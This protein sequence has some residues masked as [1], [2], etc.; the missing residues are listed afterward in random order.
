MKTI[1]VYSGQ[2]AYQAKDI[3]NFLAVFDFDYERVGGM[4]I[5]NLLHPGVLIVPGG[6]IGSFLPAWGKDGVEAIQRFVAS[7]GVYIGICSG[8][9]VAGKSFDNVAGLE[10]FPGS[11]D[12]TKHQSII[13]VTDELGG[14]WQLIAENGP[15]ISKIVVDKIILKDIEGKPQAIR[16]N[17]GQGKVFLFS[18][19]PE[20][21]VYYNQIPQNFSGAKFFKQLLETLLIE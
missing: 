17:V 8:V 2:G 4:E 6:R 14:A 1:Y 16:I 18:S 15:D 11:L 13:D 9:Y 12:Y 7:G 21:S 3:E 5:K 10:F 20:G 19:H